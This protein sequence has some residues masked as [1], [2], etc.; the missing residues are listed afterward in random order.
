VGARGGDAFAGGQA[1][2]D[3]VEEAAEGQAE[4]SGEDCADELD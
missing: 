4:K 2:E 1:S 3:Y